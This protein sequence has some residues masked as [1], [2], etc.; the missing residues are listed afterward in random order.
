MPTVRAAPLLVILPPLL[1][2]FLGHLRKGRISQTSIKPRHSPPTPVSRPPSPQRPLPEPLPGLL[3]RDP[4]V[5]AHEVKQITRTPARV[6]IPMRIVPPKDL[7][8]RTGVPPIMVL[9]KRTGPHT[10]AIQCHI[11]ANH[12]HN[13]LGST[14]R[15]NTATTSTSHPLMASYEGFVSRDE[16]FMAS[17]DRVIS[18]QMPPRRGTR[19]PL[20]HLAQPDTALLHRFPNRHP[21]PIRS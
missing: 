4:V 20:H 11:P 14:P 15:P 3:W 10:A 19:H 13:I 18:H 21:F 7:E 9:L 5:Q 8:A 17:H 16:K 12:L 6:A 1:S 2:N